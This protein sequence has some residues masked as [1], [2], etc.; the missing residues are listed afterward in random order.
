MRKAQTGQH[1][2]G[3]AFGLVV[4]A[5]VMAA[6]PA[7]AHPHIFIDGGVDFRFDGA[8]RLTELRVTWD[9]DPL[10]SLYMLEDLG[11]DGSKPLTAEERGRLAAYDTDW[12]EG[13]V[14]DTYLWNG[15]QTVAL[16]G[17][18]APEAV[19][20][21]GRVVI[22]FLRALASPF[23]PGAQ[24][25]LEMYDPEYYYAYTL[26]GAAKLEDPPAGC[27]ATVVPFEPTA[28]LAA[29]QRSLFDLPTDQTPA[30]DGV[31]ALFTDK[32]LLKCD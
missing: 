15:P 31:G 10:T 13:Y 9:Y 32:V 6:A 3:T 29:T 30:Q 12:D 1:R 5:G 11:I 8:G 18:R 7:C 2:T 20:R 17:P 24:T 19:V 27:H 21:D 23:R 22:R 16:S 28:A 26:T 25:R 4:A 14:G